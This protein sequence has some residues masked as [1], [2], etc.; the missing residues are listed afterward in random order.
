IVKIVSGQRPDLQKRRARIKQTLHPL[1]R[2]Q[3]ATLGV[4]R[5]RFFA[6]AKRDLS[7]ALAQLLRQAAMMRGVCGEGFAVGLD[8]GFGCHMEN[9]GRLPAESPAQAGPRAGI[10]RRRSTALA[11]L[12]PGS[13][14]GV[15]RGCVRE[16]L[17]LI[18]RSLPARSETGAPHSYL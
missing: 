9:L 13:H 6:A 8:V 4:P 7:R 17:L 12:D 3:L 10:Q 11:A 15:R 2:Q 14:P 5:A 16:A 18:P 1:T